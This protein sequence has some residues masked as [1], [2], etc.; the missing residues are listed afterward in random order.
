MRKLFFF[1]TALTMLFASCA[2]DATTVPAIKGEK[3]V[4]FQ[5]TAPKMQT[6]YGE[7][8][9]ANKLFWAVYKDGNI[10]GNISAIDA[11]DAVAI[12]LSTDVEITLTD[13][14]DYDILFW[15]QNENAPY[16]FDGAKVTIDYAALSANEEAYDAFFRNYHVDG[17]QTEPHRVELKRPFA[18]LNVAAADTAKAA[19]AGFS[20]ENTSVTVTT[21]TVLDLATGV[22]SEPQEMTFAMS[23]KASDT[24]GEAPDTFDIISMN[25]L[26]V[27]NEK[28]V[29]DVTFNAEGGNDAI[30]RE[31][32][33]VPLQR[34]HRTYILGDILTNA[35]L[36]EVF[37]NPAFEDEDLFN[38]PS[39]DQRQPVAGSVIY[40]TSTDGLKVNGP[41]T[42]NNGDGGITY[43][44]TDNIYENGLGI[45]YFN[46]PVTIIGAL[47]FEVNETL[48]T[49][50]L[51]DGLDWIGHGAFTY[52][53]NL[54][55]VEIPNSVTVISE[56][57]FSD[58]KL[59]SVTIPEN[60]EYL[61]EYAFSYCENLT[62]VYCRPTIPPRG[63]DKFI[64]C[65]S[66][67]TIY[68]PT[69]S[70]DDYKNADGWKEYADKIVDGGF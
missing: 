70:V 3:R 9:E 6:R 59:T 8:Q 16:T 39:D 29:V 69:E 54:A 61:G 40:Y 19:S 25:Y 1:F 15:A 11:D 17:E 28:E 43:E 51:P 2:K 67:L 21:C 48:S 7:G 34:N 45:M 55:S 5:V 57:V 22:A 18:Q 50:I 41:S 68:V 53:Y 46:E 26:L 63:G 38:D 62:T 49:I 12:N 10:L 47:A 20:V 52:C 44:M 32:L 24:Y 42:D 36:F 33:N 64:G 37:I 13:G 60:V 66:N 65:P 58:T 30:E 4:S 27:N 35:K 14:L 56:R 31:Y 23:Q